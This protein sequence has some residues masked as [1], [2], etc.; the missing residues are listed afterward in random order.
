MQF[1]QNAHY[2]ASCRLLDELHALMLNGNDGEEGDTIRDQ[3]DFHWYRLSNAETESIKLYSAELYRKEEM[4]EVATKPEEVL[5]SRWGYH[6]CTYSIFC[7]LKRLHRLY[8]ETVSD[9]FAWERWSRKQPQNRKGPEPTYNK[10]FIDDMPS[11]RQRERCGRWLKKTINDHGII[12]LYQRARMPSPEPV[13]A[14]DE[15]TLKKID[16]LLNKVEDNK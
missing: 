8:W 5:K 9:Y 7:K 4:M 6:P 11:F 13:E 3:M 14:F 12:E 15:K 10:A 2:R 1:K 16:N